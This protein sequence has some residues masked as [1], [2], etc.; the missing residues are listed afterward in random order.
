MLGLKTFQNMR[1]LYQCIDFY[2]L[3][4]SK[5]SCMSEAPKNCGAGIQFFSF[6][7]QIYNHIFELVLSNSDLNYQYSIDQL[8]LGGHCYKTL[9]LG[10][11]Q[12]FTNSQWHSQDYV[13]GWEVGIGVLETCVESL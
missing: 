4:C 8:V 12:S 10:E 5:V 13:P 11:G 9:K 1:A 2:L 7:P 6:H 3:S